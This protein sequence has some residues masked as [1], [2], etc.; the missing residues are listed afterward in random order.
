MG[1]TIDSMNAIS[2]SS[3]SYLAYRSSSVQVDPSSESGRRCKPYE[4]CAATTC[5]R[6]NSLVSRQDRYE[7]ALSASFRVE[8]P[9]AK[10]RLRRDTAGFAKEGGADDSVRVGARMPV[11]G[12]A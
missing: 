3:R 1:R 7:R 9:D 4:S 6:I 12:A 5:R 10:V 11:P 2:S 8:W